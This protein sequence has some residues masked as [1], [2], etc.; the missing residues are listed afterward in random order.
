MRTLFF[1]L[2]A[3]VPAPAQDWA[4]R[5]EGELVNY[6]RRESASPVPLVREIG[7]LPRAN[8][9]CSTFKT[10]YSPPGQKVVVKD[11]RL[12]RGP[13]ATEYYI[14]E[15]QGLRLKAQILGD[16]LLST[17]KYQSILL[18]SIMRL[19]GDTLEEDIYTATDQPATNGVLSLDTRSLQRLQ[20]RRARK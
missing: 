15:G 2:L 19:R 14:D 5:W 16:T 18:I 11:Y 3:V 1:L 13:G 20:F 10:T 4:G 8:G 9:D 17:F 12:C 6:P 7:E